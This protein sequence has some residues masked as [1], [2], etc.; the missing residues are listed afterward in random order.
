MKRR[1]LRFCVTLVLYLARPC[2]PAL[3]TVRTGHKAR[4]KPIVPSIVSYFAAANPAK[5][6]RIHPH[7][8]SRRAAGCCGRPE[9]AEA[10]PPETTAWQWSQSAFREP[11]RSIVTAS[12]NSTTTVT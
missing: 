6:A 4:P 5:A 7:P 3:R 10:T 12:W 1:F 9:S 11:K 2:G 8:A